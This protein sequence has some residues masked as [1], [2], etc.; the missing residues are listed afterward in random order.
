MTRPAPR[1][2]WMEFGL[3]TQTDPDAFFPE[4]GSSPHAAKRICGDCPV[5]IR[6]L[7]YALDHNEQYGVWGGLT[8]H[9]RRQL[10]KGAA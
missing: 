6:C 3:C 4:K 7:R 9:E 10:K 1:E 8:G 5:R 2:A